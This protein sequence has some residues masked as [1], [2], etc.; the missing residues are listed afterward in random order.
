[1]TDNDLERLREQADDERKSRLESIAA[2]GMNNE[3]DYPAIIE[4]R[5]HYYGGHEADKREKMGVDGW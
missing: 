3:P 1:M 2:H 5:E 4:E